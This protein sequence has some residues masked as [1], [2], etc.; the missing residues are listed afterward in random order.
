MLKKKKKGMTSKLVSE[1]AN[2]DLRGWQKRIMKRIEK[3]R[4]F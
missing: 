2:K 3:K 4:L 1:Y